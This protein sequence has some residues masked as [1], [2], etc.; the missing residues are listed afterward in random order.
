MA[1]D[2]RS[3][4][5]NFTGEMLRRPAVG[6]RPPVQISLPVVQGMTPEKLDPWL[7]I[8]ANAFAFLLGV[9]LLLFEAVIEKQHANPYMIGVAFALVGLPP[10]RFIDRRRREKVAELIQADPALWSGEERR[11]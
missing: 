9:F 6:R 2:L 7:S 3:D 5:E 8:A 1:S 11:K 4:A 10:A